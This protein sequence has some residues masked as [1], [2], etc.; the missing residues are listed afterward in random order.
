MASAK[1]REWLLLTCVGLAGLLIGAG[2][3][4]LSSRKTAP[5]PSV[6]EIAL[7]ANFIDIEGKA[8][9]LNQWKGKIMV[10]NFWATWCPPCITEIPEFIQLQKQY[11]NRDVTFIG[12]AVDEKAKVA[13]FMQRVKFNYPSLLG[14]LES[15][16]IAKKL[17][18]RFGTLPFTVVI[19]R[20][21]KLTSTHM[22]TLNRQQMEALIKPLL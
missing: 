12:I 16:E 2:V 5:A 13:D 18:N 20:D 9:T 11:Q 7:H 15:M 1:V 8:H 22:G 21:G 14:G 6:A 19:S 4:S 3:Y 10:V 17:G